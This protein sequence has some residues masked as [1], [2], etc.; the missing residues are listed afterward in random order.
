[1]TRAA[2]AGPT[3]DTGPHTCG[4]ACQAAAHNLVLLLQRQPR[5][6][7]VSPQR[8]SR[9]EAAAVIHEHYLDL[10]APAR[11][12]A[13]TSCQTMACMHVGA[14]SRTMSCLMDLHA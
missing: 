4:A 11:S 2:A 6:G 3:A 10:Y 5:C 14:Y 12:M 13:F 9:K 8:F 7:G 1:M